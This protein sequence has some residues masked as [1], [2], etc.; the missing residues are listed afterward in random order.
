MQQKYFI[1]VKKAKYL[2]MERIFCIVDSCCK[3]SNPMLIEMFMQTVRMK[4][5]VTEVVS[6]SKSN[7]YFIE[8]TQSSDPE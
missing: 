6:V 1:L 5:S 2:F 8:K 7:C 4:G 3:K